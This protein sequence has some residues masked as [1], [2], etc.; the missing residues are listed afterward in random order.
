METFVKLIETIAWPTTVIWLGYLFRSE[1]RQLLGRLESLKYKDAEAKFN[2]Q[3]REAEKVAPP[4]SRKLAVSWEKASA[5]GV[6]T[7]YEQFRRIAEVSPRAA[8]LEAWLDVEAAVYA[9]AER[10]KLEVRGQTNVHSLARNLMSLGKVPED[11]MPFFEQLRRLRNNAA[12]LPD[13]VLDEGEANKYLELSL[14][15]ANTF[16]EYAVSNDA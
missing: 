11:V 3:L 7:Q 4:A 13:F 10:A 15:L 1:L 5:R 14:G 12:H 2:Q 6:V 16:R 8:I 9:A